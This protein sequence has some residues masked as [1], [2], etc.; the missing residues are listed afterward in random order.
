MWK[1]PK[2]VGYYYYI[3]LIVDDGHGGTCEGIL[4]V[5]VQ[6]NKFFLSVKS[7]FG[8][9]RGEGEYEEGSLATVS[10]D[11]RGFLIF[12]FDGWKGDSNSQSS[13]ISII[14]D[15]PKVVEAKWKIDL[16]VVTILIVLF[17]VFLYLWIRSR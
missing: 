14:M 13:T 7:S 5:I 9:P 1:A 16:M 8:N 4:P 6:K 15:S 2:Y 11:D 12:L 17:G 10:V 3:K